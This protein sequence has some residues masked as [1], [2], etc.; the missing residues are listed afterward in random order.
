MKVK[1]GKPNLPKYG[2]EELFLFRWFQTRAKYQEE[3]GQ[4]APAW[5]PR[6]PPKRW[7]DP[8]AERRAQGRRSVV[9]QQIL[10]V[11]ETGLPVGGTDGKPLVDVLVLSKEQAE[12]VNIP[13]DGVANVPGADR[14]EVP[15]PLRTL[16]AGEEL[17]FDPNMPGV[18][19]V[20]NGLHPYWQREAVV[21]FTGNDRRLLVAL[22]EKQGIR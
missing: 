18:V 6:L 12:R 21:G 15:M 13:P 14:P 1:M 8:A 17:M 5:D 10:V 4:E 20:K 2:L 3:T 7:L 11:S 9:Y 22:A 16:E 19:V